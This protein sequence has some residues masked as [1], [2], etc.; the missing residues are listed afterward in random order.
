TQGVRIVQGLGAG[1]AMPVVGEIETEEQDLVI[2][3]IKDNVQPINFKLESEDDEPE[4]DVEE[5]LAKAYDA[6]EQMD[7]HNDEPSLFD[8]PVRQPAPIAPPA[9]IET[10]TSQKS[11]DAGSLAKLK[12]LRADLQAIRD[13]VEQQ[14][15]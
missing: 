13:K 14:S 8:A 2:D 10:A 9:I 11:F 12:N 1:R 3:E 15:A 7:D 6:P 5:A 4:V